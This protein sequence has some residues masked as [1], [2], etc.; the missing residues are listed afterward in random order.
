[1]K[2][3]G[4]AAP[5]KEWS[6]SYSKLKN[7][8]TCPKRHYE[9]DLAKNY[10]DGGTGLAEGNEVHDVLA[11]ACTGKQQLPV[12]HSHYQK[13]VDLVRACPGELQV[14]Q[15]YAITRDFKATNYFNPRVWYR[16]IA[17]VVHIMGDIAKARDW[18]TGKVLED[19]VQ[20]MLMATCLF[21]HKPE[22][23]RVITE[24][25][26]L[27]EDCTSVEVFDRAEVARELSRLM[28][29]IDKLEQAAK[30]QDYP[31]TPNGLCKNFCKVT[32]CVFHG[33]GA[34]R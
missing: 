13:W 22:L 5:P 12:N 23:K 27:K 24:Y 11:K 3:Q 2:A 21:V 25:V 1:M 28:P 18:K 9:I 14:E 16:G 30:A 17:D 33:K 6:W 4:I 31:P 29:N 32:S 15:K 20:L 8:N 26:W 19:P 10:I 34:R 7:Y